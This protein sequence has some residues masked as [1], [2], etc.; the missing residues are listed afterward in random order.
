MEYKISFPD[1]GEIVYI[2][3]LPDDKWARSENP[4]ELIIVD[5]NKQGD[6]IGVEFHWL[7]SGE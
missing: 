1:N 6:M 2:S 3:I 4:D 7:N 5:Y